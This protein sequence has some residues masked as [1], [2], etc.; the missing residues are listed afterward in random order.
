MPSF[1]LI[2]ALE[3][4]RVV[5]SLQQQASIASLSQ[6]TTTPVTPY[7][8]G[9]YHHHTFPR[10]GN[11]GGTRS[12]TPSLPFLEG[13][14]REVYDASFG[15]PLN[16]RS[17]PQIP[18]QPL[19]ELDVPSQIPIISVTPEGRPASLVDTET[20]T[21]TELSQS[22]YSQHHSKRKR[23]WRRLGKIF[24]ILF[25]TLHDF[26]SKSFLGKIA[27]LFAAPAVLALTL[28]LPVV[29]TSYDGPSEAEEKLLNVNSS[30]AS[31]HGDGNG[32]GVGSMV[33][34]A[35]GRLVDFEEE[36]VERTLV[37]EEEVELELHELKFNKWL[38]AVQCVFGPM[39]CIAVLFGEFEG[40]LLD[41]ALWS[42]FLTRIHRRSSERAMVASRCCSNRIDLC[43]HRGRI[44]TPRRWCRSKTRKML[45]GVHGS[46]GLDNGH[47]GR[48]CRSTHSKFRLPGVPSHTHTHP[49]LPLSFPFPFPLLL[50]LLLP[51]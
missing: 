46:N 34:T 5:T 26:K 30:A 37:A 41:S 28:T 7:S 17:P 14:D 20:E 39:F 18:E 23:V 24:H 25:P 42:T 38:M 12:R 51:S 43:N 33:A 19:L 35:D 27:A 31:I 2:G 10:N 6:F 8:A 29:I 22:A 50:L 45:H 3:F 49:C 13:R 1:S 36:G 32:Y 9:H 15:L 21:E 16:D 48:S 40:S 11:S 4:R 47:R 44:C